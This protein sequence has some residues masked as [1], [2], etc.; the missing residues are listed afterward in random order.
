MTAA[1]IDASDA[2]L[3]ASIA[4]AVILG[5]VI[6]RHLLKQDALAEAKPEAIVELVRPLFRS[7][8]KPGLR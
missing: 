7:L 8:V 1:A 3:R 2:P 4:N 5:L 6:G